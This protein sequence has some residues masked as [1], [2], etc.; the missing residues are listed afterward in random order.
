MY[1]LYATKVGLAVGDIN[2]V[3]QNADISLIQ[4]DLNFIM[5]AKNYPLPIWIRK[6]IYKPS[7]EIQYHSKSSMKEK[8]S[9][10]CLFPLITTKY[11]RMYNF[12]YI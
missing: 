2:E 11:I 7:L 5:L 10:A 1:I 12:L 3:R 9:Y 8:V 4:K 6:Y